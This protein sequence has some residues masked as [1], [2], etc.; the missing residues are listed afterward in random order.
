MKHGGGLKVHRRVIR[1]PSSALGFRG[2][3]IAVEVDAGSGD[4]PDELAGVVLARVGEEL[5][6]CPGLHD[7]PVLP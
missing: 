7:A 1:C 2:N 5:V 3:L 6:G 4:G